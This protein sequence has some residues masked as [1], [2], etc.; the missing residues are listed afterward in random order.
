M[1]IKKLLPLLFL[2]AGLQVNAAVIITADDV[3]ND[4]NLEW[5]NLNHT[6][7]RLPADAVTEFGGNGNGFRM[8]S[9]AEAAGLIDGWFGVSMTVDH[10]N[11]G[12]DA[13]LIGE[14][15]SQFGF[16]NNFAGVFGIVAD[17]GGMFGARVKGKGLLFSGWDCEC[18][19][20]GAGGAASAYAGYWMVR[21]VE[22]PEPSIMAL[23]T[24]GVVGIGLARRRQS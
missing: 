4:G 14:F 17:G 18:G 16:T 9:V 22:V 19:D 24:F 7:N 3:Y 23:F 8:A 20:Y 11:G 2:F 10:V 6:I 5:L 12:F 13:E 21:S 15:A 1:M